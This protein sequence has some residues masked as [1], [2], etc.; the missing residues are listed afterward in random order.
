MG[1]RTGR[2]NGAITPSGL[3]FE[4]LTPQFGVWVILFDT[5]KGEASEEE[6]GRQSV[7]TEKATYQKWKPT[8]T[9]KRS[10]KLWV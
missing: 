6:R 4:T 9:T 8:L 1:D 5:S 2:L 10:R 3:R 7:L